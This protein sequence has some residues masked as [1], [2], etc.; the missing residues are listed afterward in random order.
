[1]EKCD[2]ILIYINTA[3]NITQLC[4]LAI[5][6]NR[7]LIVFIAWIAS[8]YAGYSIISRRKSVYHKLLCAIPVTFA[9]PQMFSYMSTI[10]IS[11]FV[12]AWGQT[13]LGA[14]AYVTQSPNIWPEYF[15]YH[16]VMHLLTSTAALT[17]I[18]LQYHLLES[19]DSSHCLLSGMEG[20]FR[21]VFWR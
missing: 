3:N 13:F 19:F 16:E 15:G 5:R 18:A 10:Q 14:M 8:M 21:D 7:L 17:A 6:N 1:M 9:L 11:L 2:H 4:L 20:S 12:A